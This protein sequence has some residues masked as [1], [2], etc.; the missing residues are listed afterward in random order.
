MNKKN[1]QA[2]IH[3][4]KDIV[5]AD[6]ISKVPHPKVVIPNN[7]LHDLIRAIVYQQ[8]ST[9]AA[10]KIYH[11]L[12][13]LLDFNLSDPNRVV[14]LQEDQLKAVGLSRQKTSYVF[15]IAQF[16]IEEQ[17]KDE[18]WETMSD[19]A[20]IKYLTQ[21]K[22]VGKWTVEMILIFTLYRADIFPDGDYAIQIVMKD[23]YKIKKEKKAL[24]IAMNKKAEKWKPY[25]SLA[26]RYLWQ[27]IREQRKAKQEKKSKK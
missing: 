2:V 18:V 24:L 27:H 15:N 7:V 13:E 1:K 12:Q 19:E 3:L 17:I 16:F 4:Q 10:D 21:I 25:R 23:L 14:A 5:L 20:I 8:I 9:K 22:G 11:R 6:I 26:T